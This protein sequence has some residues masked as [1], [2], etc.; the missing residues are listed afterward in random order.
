[1]GQLENKNKNNDNNNNNNNSNNSLEVT[2]VIFYAS[3]GDD[4]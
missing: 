2:G 4:D 3:C 1:V